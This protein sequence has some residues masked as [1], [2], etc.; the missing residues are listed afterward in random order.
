MLPII[1]SKIREH[2]L[3]LHPIKGYLKKKKTKADPLEIFKE[4]AFQSSTE[5]AADFAKAF[6]NIE[7][8]FTGKKPHTVPFKET[9]LSI[10]PDQMQDLPL[11]GIGASEFKE[12]VDLFNQI[13]G[14]SKIVCEGNKEFR[15]QI[16]KSVLI[17]L[18]RELGRDL[19]RELFSP[20]VDK[21]VIKPAN[22]QLSQTY[23]DEAQQANIILIN[24]QT[25]YTYV[26]SKN[27]HLLEYFQLPFVLVHE[28]IHVLHK[29]R[30]SLTVP[31]S[32]L[33]ACHLHSNILETGAIFGL[34]EPMPIVKAKK[35][36]HNPKLKLKYSRFS[37]N[38][39]RAVLGQSA[40]LYHLGFELPTDLKIT[41]FE[42]LR[43]HF[44]TIVTYFGE[45]EFRD[46]IN[47]NPHIF[48]V[49]DFYM[50]FLI[51]ASGFQAHS[52]LRLLLEIP[53]VQFLDNSDIMNLINNVLAEN[54]KKN[55]LLYL[56]SKKFKDFI[57][58]YKVLLFKAIYNPLIE[59]EAIFKF[60]NFFLDQLN[61]QNQE[62]EF[63]LSMLKFQCQHAKIEMYPD[64]ALPEHSDSQSSS[65][66][67]NGK[68]APNPLQS[69]PSP[70]PLLNNGVVPVTRPYAN[71][72]FTGDDKNVRFSRKSYR[73]S[74]NPPFK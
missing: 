32:Y 41:N 66:S 27:R 11:N 51:C 13:I 67:N 55:L 73:Q 57:L 28:L 18:T 63:F 29:H 17:L 68:E 36:W 71:N 19:F 24:D 25:S 53:Q 14:G 62:R 35:F 2:F 15:E 5:E 45:K 4:K 49:K 48:S 70:S 8:V 38:N 12:T 3:C 58:K 22:N 59:D 30:S 46:F 42:F 39:F 33:G 9:D 31:K 34:S 40:R 60:A 64:C 6:E 43:T 69:S 52:S 26:S 20:D 1:M 16:V 50:G 65:S 74:S 56:E 72:A 61:I 44:G 47:A 21:I 54:N 37:E 7:E 23:Y 10:Y